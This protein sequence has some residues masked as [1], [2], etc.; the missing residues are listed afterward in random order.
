[1]AVPK[2]KTPGVIGIVAVSVLAALYLLYYGGWFVYALLTLRT[3]AT[4]QGGL[5]GDPA[6]A[7]AAIQTLILMP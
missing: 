5:P 4:L 3:D 7:A 6:S 2:V 1:M